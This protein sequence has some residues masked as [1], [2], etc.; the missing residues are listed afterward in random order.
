MKSVVVVT[1]CSRGLGLDIALRLLALDYLVVGVSRTNPL[2]VNDNFDFLECD[3]GDIDATTALG[4]L[5]VKKYPD[6]YGLVN[7]AAVGADGLLS[8]QHNSE[9]ESAVRTNLLSPIVLTKYLSRPMLL[10]S[11]G[12]IINISSVVANTGYRGLSVY[13]ATK[14]GLVSFTHS[15]SR[16]LGPANITVNCILP[17]FMASA[18]TSNI[19]SKS[20]DKIAARS[21]LK[22]LVDFQD[23]SAMV[24][25]LLSDAGANITGTSIVIDAGN[26]A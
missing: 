8:T 20:L 25:H 22:K 17:G 2:I 16:D 19:D 24:E 3:L 10:N 23:V 15:L 5:I 14:G 1:G 11:R 9:I 13:A 26:S 4:V 21:A 12:R 6:L 18:M 7:N